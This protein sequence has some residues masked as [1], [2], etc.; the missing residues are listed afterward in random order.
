MLS[1]RPLSRSR[2]PPAS[3]L[4]PPPPSARPRATPSCGRSFARW[5]AVVSRQ[6]LT[7]PPMLVGEPLGQRFK[8]LVEGDP[9]GILAASARPRYGYG[10]G[11]RS[12][13]DG[14]GM[15]GSRYSL[16]DGKETLMG[17]AFGGGAA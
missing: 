12:S 13:R 15:P 6:A 3:I 7:V 1:T 9:H 2:P 5:S 10:S 14:R 17:A 11:A 4:H 16:A 8:A